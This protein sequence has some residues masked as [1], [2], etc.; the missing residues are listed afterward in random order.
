M[1]YLILS[2]KARCWKPPGH[3]VMHTHFH[4]QTPACVGH[5]CKVK[6]IYKEIKFQFLFNLA[7]NP[8]SK[9]SDLFLY[10]NNL[11]YKYEIHSTV[12]LDWINRHNN[13][14]IWDR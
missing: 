10:H 3:Y 12:K 5:A 11:E 1:F 4:S 14:N 6:L 9:G 2:F 8:V 13:Y 7:G